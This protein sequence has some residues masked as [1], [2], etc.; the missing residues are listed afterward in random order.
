[1]PA[2]IKPSQIHTG[3]PH[4]IAGASKIVKS[5]SSASPNSTKVSSKTP[6]GSKSLSKS[7][8][9]SKSVTK[10]T[11]KLANKANI[12]QDIDPVKLD[13][14]SFGMP[15]LRK[16]KQVYKLNVKARASKDDLVLAVNS[17]HDQLPVDEVDTI[18]RFLFN[19]RNKRH[20]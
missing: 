4:P 8:P 15:L 6:N 17:H 1:M 3:T 19:I 18:A 12:K 11:T 9:S 14:H 7:T 10:S 20:L 16:Y 2:K 5:Y 13:F